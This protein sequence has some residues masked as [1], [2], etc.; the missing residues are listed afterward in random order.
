MTP[1]LLTLPPFTVCI[2]LNQFYYNEK[3]HVLEM[4]LGF[5]IMF[6]ELFNEY[7]YIKESTKSTTD[8]RGHMEKWSS[9]RLVMFLH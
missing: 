4:G 1:T 5:L 7:Q 8:S 9:L 3:L 6:S 2:I